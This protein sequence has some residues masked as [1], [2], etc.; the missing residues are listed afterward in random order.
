M[1]RKK[2]ITSISMLGLSPSLLKTGY[3]TPCIKQHEYD[4]IVIGVGSMGSSTCY[5]LAK[6]GYKVLGIEQFDIV[7]EHGSHLGQSRIIRK[8][9]F[10]HPD[11]VPLL[12]RAYANWHELEE[13]TGKQIYYRTGL[14]YHGRSSHS[15]ISDTKMASRRYNIPVH[16]ISKTHL[17][18][19]YPQF[20]IPAVYETILEPD[21]GFVTPENA[22]LLYTE[23]AMKKGAVIHTRE[24][25]TEWKKE[26]AGVTVVTD[27]G[28]YRAKKLIITMGAWAGKAISK[29]NVP[30]KVTK[31][32]VAWMD[33]KNREAFALNT[34]PCWMVSDDTNGLY[35]GFPLLPAAT[36]GAPLGL[37]AAR[38]DVGKVVD[39]DQVDRTISAEE[40]QELRG[41]LASFIPD[42][43]N[44]VLTLKS[45]LYTHSKDENFIIDHLPGYNGDV[46]IA[47]GFSGHGFKFVSVMGE[48]LTDMAMLGKTSLP[49]EF[50]SLKRFL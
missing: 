2:F 5:Y 25:V 44:K 41:G 27:K 10:E 45:C 49:V 12:Q 31:Q 11:Y 37:K 33:P 24:K 22:I 3:A 39:P 16:E 14:I 21:A 47:C 6:K 46:V 42:A 20:S 26:R 34:F 28:T 35:Y 50:L 7:H 32:V 30:L 18:N 4:A 15:I 29:I 9:Y 48:V 23:A 40:E 8:A 13:L 17:L 1:N 19:N 43:N 36:F 38:D